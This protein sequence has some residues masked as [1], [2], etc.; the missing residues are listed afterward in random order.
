MTIETLALSETFGKMVLGT[1][2][3]NI[4]GLEQAEVIEQFNTSSLLLFRGFDIDTADFKK[5]TELFSTS[6]VSYVG[7]AYSREMI[8]GDKTLL[9]V[10]GGKLAFPVPLHGEMYYR[11]QKPDILWFYCA[12][13]ALKDGETT[14]CD[15]IQI[16]NQLSSSTQELF[17][18]KKL[19]YIRTYPTGIWQK[20]YQTDD[21]SHV[22]AVCKDN[23]MQLEADKEQVTTHYIASAIQ[24]SRSGRNQ[25]F[26]NNILP[27]IAQELNG[28]TSSL[29]RLEDGS[30][31]PDSVIDEIKTITEKLIYLVSWQ[32]GDILMI[33]NTRLMH[34]RRA[35]ADNQRDIYVRLCEASFPF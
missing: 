7:G 29:V 32:K 28:N 2:K 33:D 27:V 18:E 25:V 5:F 4:C 17:Q 10:T 24:P 13:P 8:N 14:I 12:S 1:T 21:L 15:G 22:E 30:K 31:I 6:F 35:F 3:Q 11:K 23:E 20:I 26:I 34:G 9:S 19:K 16:Y